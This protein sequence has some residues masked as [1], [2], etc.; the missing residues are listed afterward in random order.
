LESRAAAETPI[1]RNTQGRGA[2]VTNP[3]LDI[4]SSSSSSSTRRHTPLKAK[5]NASTQVCLFT[6]FVSVDTGNTNR[7]LES[8]EVDMKEYMYGS[9]KYKGQASSN[10][11][12]Y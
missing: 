12:D 4:R 7:E 8:T 1:Q 6:N 5:G 10:E 3:H 9:L 2:P 11:G